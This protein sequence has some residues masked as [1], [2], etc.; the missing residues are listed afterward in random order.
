MGYWSTIEIDVG[1]ICACLPGARSLI[2]HLFPSVFPSTIAATK[3]SHTRSAASGSA[4]EV[5]F[6]P[7]QKRSNSDFIPLVEVDHKARNDNP[8]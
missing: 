3:G 5:N 2:I 4:L 1:V 6:T 7:R 8:Y